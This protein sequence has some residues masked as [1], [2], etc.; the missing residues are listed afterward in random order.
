VATRNSSG[1]DRFHPRGNVSHSVEFDLTN[2]DRLLTT[3][4]QVRKRLDLSRP[5]PIELVLECIQVA[6][7]AP[8]GANRESN[9]WLIIDEA[10]IKAELAKLY[11]RRMDPYLSALP[12]AP[13]GSRQ[14]KVNESTKYL[15][16]HMAEVPLI[17]IPLRL[18][19]VSEKADVRER[20]SFYGSVIPAVWSFQLAARSRGL[21]SA[22][23]TGHLAFETE[24]A[25]L[26]GLPAPRPQ[27]TAINQAEAAPSDLVTQICLLPVAF[28]KGGGFVSA[29]RL[30]A[31]E[32]TFLNHWGNSLSGTG[33]AAEP[34]PGS[35]G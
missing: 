23:T 12:V 30:P 4:K 7:A 6:S 17:V 10:E 26:L 24:A 33:A 15:I 9:R 19:R 13:P 8:I 27:P 1:S 11:R 22:F 25:E 16:D 21:G 32:V 28:Y 3:T 5:V 35:V 18:S 31:H 29:P 2:T 14:A 34:Q 20:S